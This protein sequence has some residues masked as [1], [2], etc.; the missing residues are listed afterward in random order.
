MKKLY[1][2]RAEQQEAYRNRQ[3]AKQESATEEAEERAQCIA[4]NLSSFG[5][6]GFEKPARTCIEEFQVHR[7][8]LRALDQ[9]D[10]LPG[11]SLRDLARRT[12]DALLNS[13]AL[14]IMTDGGGKWID[15]QWVP[16]SDVWLP[17]LDPNLQN[18]QGWFGE[19]IYG[20]AK[21]DWFD[22]HW[23]PP[24][25]CSSDEPIDLKSL[26]PLPPIR[27]VRNFKP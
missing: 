15:G 27:K 13:S 19:V 6:V 23:V 9:P 3:K 4:R 14:G 18:F 21:P 25:D 12:W 5:E 7:S 10:L 2:N 11:E 22:A 26:P 24:K 17:Y 20:A 1:K 8:W 16:G